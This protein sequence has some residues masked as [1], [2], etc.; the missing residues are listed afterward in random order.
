MQLLQL[1]AFLALAASC[2]CDMLWDPS[3]VIPGKANLAC[4]F[5]RD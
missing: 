3:A 1:A 2:S 5:Y 4:A